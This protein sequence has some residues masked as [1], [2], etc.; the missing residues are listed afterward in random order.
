[1]EIIG[2]KTNEGFYL[3]EQP[4]DIYGRTNLAN[5]LINGE[6]PKTTFH[7]N[8]VHVTGKPSKIEQFVSQPDINHRYELVDKSLESEKFPLVFQREDVTYYDEDEYERMW[9]DEF[10]H[11]RS[12]Y[13]LKYDKQDSKNVEV[14]FT[15]E[16]ICE[17]DEIKSPEGFSYQVQKTQWEH[18]GTKNL[19]EKDVHHQLIDKIMFPEI[20]L[21]QKTSKFTSKQMYDIVRQYIKQHINYDYAEIT[22]DYNF[23]FTVKKKIQLN[24]PHMNKREI[25]KS[26]GRPYKSPKYHKRYIKD[27]KAEVFE[28]TST[29]DNHKGYT[30]IPEMIG[31]SIED[32]QQKVDRYC[33]ELIKIINKPLVDC[34]HCSGHGVIDH[35]KKV[36]TKEFFQ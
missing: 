18:E 19:T 2:V 30:P 36:K 24:D 13:E 25:M 23:C 32:L 14:E 29:K 20:V 34:P 5:Y 11:L 12:L 27:R 28:M 17:I 6:H 3:S 8:W 7:R 33:E 22:S 35:D 9:K 15:Y 26:N 1:L 21:G 16:T 10:S 31:D 4:N